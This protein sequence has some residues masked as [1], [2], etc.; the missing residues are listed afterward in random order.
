M[1]RSETSRA[2]CNGNATLLS[3]PAFYLY[4]DV[5]DLVNICLYY[6]KF[7]DL[8]VEMEFAPDLRLSSP[9]LHFPTRVLLRCSSLESKKHF[10]YKST[11]VWLASMGQ[12]A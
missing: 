7:H 12:L 4:I 3:L 8:K 9:A 11:D 1:T 10:T 5:L 2:H 6:H